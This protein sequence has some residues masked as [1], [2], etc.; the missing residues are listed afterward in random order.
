MLPQ[1]SWEFMILDA[2]HWSKC[3][4]WWYAGCLLCIERFCNSHQ[5][6]LTSPPYLTH[7]Q[8]SFTMVMNIIMISIIPHHY[9]WHEHNQTVEFS[10]KDQF[11][12]WWSWTLLWLMWS[13]AWWSLFWIWSWWFDSNTIIN[14]LPDIC[15]MHQMR[16][17]CQ[18]F[19]HGVKTSRIN[20]FLMFLGVRK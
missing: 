8:L 9:D 6:A 16:C 14:V 5:I 19:Q 17:R 15:H 7:T 12:S 18:I 1:V 3:K 4:W 13:W 10:I 2:K 20:V 11:S